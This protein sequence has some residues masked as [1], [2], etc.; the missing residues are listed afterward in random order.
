MKKRT[1]AMLLTVLLV[2]SVVPVMAM[3]AESCEHKNLM[4]V[5][6]ATDTHIQMCSDCMMY[7]VATSEKPHT[8]HDGACVVCGCP[9][10]GESLPEVT[11]PEET[12]PEAP[13]C[14]HEAAPGSY[15]RN[16]FESHTA[17][18]SKCGEEFTVHCVYGQD[19]KCVCG[20]TDP[21][22]AGEETEPEETKPEVTEPEESK[23]E[24]TEPEETKPEV[25]VP[26][27]KDDNL[28]DVPK[29]GDSGFVTVCAGMMALAAVS[30]AAY[31]LNKKRAA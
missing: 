23:P 5:P 8:F 11:E 9:A 30:V 27:D 19:H 6:T 3:A 15:I 1:L 4:W 10:P 28:D 31:E 17:T 22:Y 7:V 20:N 26:D 29:T 2:V 24:E 18:C 12:E 21:A 16:A 14:E 13:A 25:T